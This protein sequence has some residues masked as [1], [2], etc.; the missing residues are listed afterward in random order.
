METSAIR[1]TVDALRTRPTADVLVIGGGVNGLAVLRDLALQGVDAALVE[2]DDFASGASGASSHMIHGGI[3]YLENGE[4]RL[5]R[6]SVQE[7]NRLLRTAPHLVTPLRTVVPIASFWS[8]LLAAP[9]R[10]LTHVQRRPRERG[11]LLIKVGLTIYD[12]FS[13]GNGLVPRHRF[14]GRARTRTEFPAF[15]ERVRYSAR[16]FDA[17]IPDPERLCLDLAHDAIEAGARA[18]NHVRAVGF[19]DGEVM[20]RDEVSGAEFGFTARVVLNAS[21]PWTDL[22]N[23]ALG[24]PSRHMGGTKGSHI[25]LDD[26]E[27]LAATDGSEIFFENSDGRVVLIYP[28][29]GRVMVGTTDLDADPRSPPCAR[30]RRSTTSPISWASCSPASRCAVSASSTASRASVPC[31]ATTTSSRASSRA[32]TESSRSNERGSSC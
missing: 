21:G 11:A 25:V 4:F 24:A 3:R 12:T 19:R 18:V 6:E 27:L 10:M 32:T 20:L 31:R 1:E 13:R 7:R 28:L 2:A 22:T 16:Y 15:H 26:P 30:R 9:M 23:A 29:K 5:V 14:A 8:G 17:S